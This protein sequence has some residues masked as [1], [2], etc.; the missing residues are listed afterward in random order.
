MCFLKKARLLK[1]IILGC[2]AFFVVFVGKCYNH[3]FQKEE[4]TEQND[5]IITANE[6]VETDK[7]G[8][9]IYP[10]LAGKSIVSFQRI[11]PDSYIDQ[12]QNECVIQLL[13]KRTS[14]ND[15]QCFSNGYTYVLVSYGETTSSVYIDAQPLSVDEN[16]D[17][18]LNYKFAISDSSSGVLKPVYYL[19]QIPTNKTI[20]TIDNSVYM[21]DIDFSSE[22]NEQLSTNS[23]GGDLGD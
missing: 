2:I 1:I 15:V 9:Y 7:N 13:K 22:E 20:R 18:I 12:Q 14:A 10:D 6:S 8:G 4:I 23:M 16:G 21:N 19:F 3:L 17:L 5:F 11:I